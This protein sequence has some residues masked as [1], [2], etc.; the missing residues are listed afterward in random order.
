[1][2][3]LICN[4]TYLVQLQAG[5]LFWQH[6]LLFV[7]DVVGASRYYFSKLPYCSA[8]DI[9]LSGFCRTFIECTLALI[10]YPLA[11]LAHERDP[12]QDK[13]TML[14]P[15][16]ARHL[17]GSTGAQP[18]PSLPAGSP[19]SAPPEGALP[20]FPQGPVSPFG[21]EEGPQ[22]PDWGWRHHRRQQQRPT[23]RSSLP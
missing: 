18:L 6:V 2:C 14:N 5:V 17:R 13:C 9:L 21:P 19:L 11:A 8:I 10:G 20:G 15:S 4:H 12:A 1:M 22:Q 3:H 16:A 23:G 7:G